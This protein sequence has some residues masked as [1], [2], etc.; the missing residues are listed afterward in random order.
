M[1]K[2]QK[3][4]K[5][6]VCGY[7]HIGDNAPESCPICG[8]SSKEFELIEEHLEHKMENPSIKDS[9][10]IVII[11]GGI[12][13]LSAAEEIRKNSDTA[14]VTIISSETQLPYY[15]LNLTRYLAKEIEKD[16]LEIHPLDWYQKNRINLINGKEAIDIDTAEK[17]VQLSDHSILSYDTLILAAGA[18]PFIPPIPGSKLNNVFTIRT[19]EDVDQILNK[20]EETNSCI[21]IGGGILGLEAAGAIAKSGIK[22]RLLE[23]S[24]W[25]MPRQLNKKAS[26]ILKGCLGEI[27][28]EVIEKARTKE[29]LGD[30]SCE[31]VV[32]ETGEIINSKLIVIAAGVRPNTALAKKAGLEVDKGL[33]VNNFLQTSGD[34]IYSAGD[35]TEHNGTLYG[36]WNV[37]QYQGK[38]AGLN[39][40]GIPTQ[41]GGVPRSNI[42]KVLNLDMFSIGEFTPLDETYCQLEKEDGKK[43]Y[44]FV[45]RDGKIVGSIILG[46]MNISMSVKK[47]IEGG[48]R[49]PVDH[50]K[51]VDQLLAMLKKE[52]N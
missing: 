21:C 16:S 3:S 22:V 37:A 39:A 35:V 48:A 17:K 4:W 49:F 20:I 30:G 29:V 18:Y 24:E 44:S 41:F 15:R 34:D 47:A 2:G 31:G 8:V 42:L 10:R 27:G 46:D 36:L 25:L 52:S 14:E 5:C 43:Y 7:V 51:D 26:S 50:I 13:G 33:V 32:L 9:S 6:L 19:V 45:L 1:S 28:I 12:A 23:G 38:V 11:G 40:I